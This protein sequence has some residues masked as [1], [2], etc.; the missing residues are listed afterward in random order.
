[1][2]RVFF[3]AAFEWE[4][5]CQDGTPA[6]VCRCECSRTWPQKCGYFGKEINERLVRGG[7][8]DEMGLQSEFKGK[9]ERAGGRAERPCLR[10]PC[11]KTWT[12]EK[13]TWGWGVGGGAETEDFWSGGG[14]M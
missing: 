1:M 13:G 8:L 6:D 10:V 5:T 11:T 9:P 7:F 4:K 12:Q 2:Y 3:K 14:F